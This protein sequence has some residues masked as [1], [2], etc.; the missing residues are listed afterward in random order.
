MKSRRDH[1]ILSNQ[2]LFKIYAMADRLKVGILG[3]G[4]NSAVGAVHFSAIKMDDEFSSECGCFSRDPSMNKNTA[5]KWHIPQS[6]TYTTASEMLE[7][8]R[9]YLDAVVILTPTPVHS[10]IVLQALNLGYP[11]ICE[12]PLASSARE[13]LEIAN[14]VKK[15]NLFLAV[16][17]NYTGY[18]MLRE[19]KHQIEVGKFGKVR[20]ILVEM[21]QDSFVRLDDS[22]NPLRPQTWRLQDNGAVP[23]VSSDLG[24]HLQNIV[25]FL[26]RAKP[27]GLV[28]VQ[29]SG[30][31]FPDLVD[32]VSCIATY[33]ND[34]TCMIWY[35]K[36]SLGHRN[37]LRVQ[38]FGTDGSA[39]WY[40]M[41]PEQLDL[42]DKSGQRQIIDRANHS[43]E[44]CNLPRY[45]RFKAG[46]PGG[47]IEAFANL[48]VDIA[49]AIRSYKRLGYQSDN[50]YIA[51][52]AQGFDCLSMLEAIADSSKTQKWV[53]M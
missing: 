19:L 37:G 11:V 48:Y 18:P 15:N 6:R 44:I 52:A 2:Q 38:V 49:D 46:H 30:G 53:F 42:C 43:V 12:K 41:N 50:P 29:S 35:T 3:G 21:P 28:A 33:A 20:Q 24:S 1:C 9:G 32:T 8:E 4:L 5:E 36:A 51:T 25:H 13:A 16:T 7:K 39:E 10:S 22:K 23:T 47:F 17:Y 45:N 14:L 34:M 26:T 31:N 27:T 40:Q